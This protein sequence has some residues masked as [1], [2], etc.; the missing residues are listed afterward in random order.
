VEYL[1]SFEKDSHYFFVKSNSYLYLHHTFSLFS[2]DLFPSSSFAP[3]IFV[4]IIPYLSIPHES[5]KL[6]Y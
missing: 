3:R 4:H 6:S 1:S 2:D 5:G